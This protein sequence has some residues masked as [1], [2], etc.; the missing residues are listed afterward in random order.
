MPAETCPYPLDLGG[1]NACPPEDVEGAYGYDEFVEVIADF[2]RP[3]HE[4]MFDWQAGDLIPPQTTT[5]AFRPAF[6][7]SSSERQ[8]GLRSTATSLDS[9]S[10]HKSRGGSLRSGRKL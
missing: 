5:T 6:S 9:W 8:D 7:A 3:V 2:T 4:H 10:L 1:A